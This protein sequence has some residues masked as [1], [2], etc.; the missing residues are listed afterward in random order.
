MVSQTA[1]RR[2][3]TISGHFGVGL[4]AEDVTAP[5][6]NLLPLNCSGNLSTPFQRLDNRL[7]YGRQ[8]SASQGHFMRQAVTPSEQNCDS[9]VSTPFRRLDNRL[10]YGRQGSAS[11]GYF[12]RQAVTPLEQGEPAQ[13][14]VSCRN[15]V[16]NQKSTASPTPPLF[17][18]LGGTE[19]QFARPKAEF[20]CSNAR[21]IEPDAQVDMSAAS[22]CPEFAR[23]VERTSKMKKFN[24]KNP[25]ISSQI[26]EWSPR[27]NV[28][29]SKC[30]YVITVELPGVD[31]RDIR[32]EMDDK[33]LIVRG[34]RTTKWQNAGGCSNDSFVT[35]HKREISQGQYRVVWPLPTC[36]NKDSVFAEFVEGLL[37]IT[38]SKL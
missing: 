14:D 6:T 31:I 30:S 1:R 15:N 20:R 35:Y 8:A 11:Q 13:P 7:H 36:A 5:T 22:E 34:E 2:V 29:E 9:N 38:I 33:N 12:M 19:P 18:R 24:T 17:S 3:N 4:L 16:T 26:H 37:Q 25:T 10:L 32:V 21:V 27:I 23:P 28:V